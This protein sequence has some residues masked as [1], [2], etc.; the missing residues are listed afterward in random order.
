MFLTGFVAFGIIFVVEVTGP[1][2]IVVAKYLTGQIAVFVPNPGYI[3]VFIVGIG[4]TIL[5]FN[6]LTRKFFFQ[7][8]QFFIKYFVTSL[9]FSY[10]C[11]L[12]SVV[13]R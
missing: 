1:A 2:A 11:G 8:V 4:C 12:F 6:R 5:I 3:A 7:L 13:L 10:I 9:R